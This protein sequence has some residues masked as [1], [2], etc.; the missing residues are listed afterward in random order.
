MN[1]KFKHDLHQELVQVANDQ[2][3]SVAALIVQICKEYLSHNSGETQK[4]EARK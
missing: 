4:D 3:C 1:V 2:G